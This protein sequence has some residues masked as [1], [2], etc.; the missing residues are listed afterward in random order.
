M[1][2]EN[3]MSKY[4]KNDKLRNW[5]DSTYQ[6]TG[7]EWLKVGLKKIIEQYE[8]TEQGIYIRSVAANKGR[9]EK[10]VFNYLK[11]EQLNIEFLLSDLEAE[12]FDDKEDDMEGF[13]YI[14]SNMD[15]KN[16]DGQ[17]DIILDIKGALWYANNITLTKRAL[18]KKKE[19][20]ELL[21]AYYRSLKNNDSLLVYDMTKNK[22]F[23]SHIFNVYRIKKGKALLKVSFFGED[24]TYK[25]FNS[26][27]KIIKAD[28]LVHKIEIN[29]TDTGH[30]L[31]EYMNLAYITKKELGE[32]I[33][34][35][36]DCS[37]MQ[38]L[39]LIGLK[40]TSLQ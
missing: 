5:Y 15:A 13:K 19:L 24:S 33:R 14:P 11:S 8:H 7:A 10:E 4:G 22:N 17:V 6:L 40:F 20:I 25:K 29:L 3:K 1:M 23:I 31:C 32:I 36:N 12:E 28:N 27:L 21:N 30:K 38:T 9:Y 35:L 2:G 34:R 18:E 37:K 26:I 16:I 39:K